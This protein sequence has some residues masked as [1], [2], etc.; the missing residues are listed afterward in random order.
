MGPTAMLAQ[1]SAR[2]VQRVSTA[3]SRVL[4]LL[5]SAQEESTRPSGRHRALRALLGLTAPQA[6]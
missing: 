3:P 5:G 6:R 4:R 2:R 1:Q